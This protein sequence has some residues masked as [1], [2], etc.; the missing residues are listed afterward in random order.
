MALQFF[1]YLEDTREL[2]DKR[3]VLGLAVGVTACFALLSIKIKN[4]FVAWIGGFSFAIYLYQSF[5][6]KVAKTIVFDLFQFS[7]IPALLTIICFTVALGI[8]IHLFSMQ[9][10]FSRGLFLGIWKPS[11]KKEFNPI[12]G[13]KLAWRNSKRELRNALG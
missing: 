12:K 9:F 8:S 10:K 13:V 5:T 1:C 4:N 3:T 11:A 2:F 7:G 6:T